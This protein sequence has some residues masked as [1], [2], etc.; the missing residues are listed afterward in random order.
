MMKKVKTSETL[1]VIKYPKYLCFE[2]CDVGELPNDNRAMKLV[3]KAFKSF[4]SLD[5]QKNTLH[6]LSHDPEKKSTLQKYFKKAKGNKVYSIDV[7]KRGASQ[8]GDRRVL[9][10]YGGSNIAKI[11]TIFT[12]SS[13]H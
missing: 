5:L 13:H 11:L 8:H 4:R 9:F 3:I 2:N 10:Y 7:G 12:D 1:H 6:P